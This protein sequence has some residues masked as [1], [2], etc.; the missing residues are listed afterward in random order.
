VSSAEVEAAL[1]SS[2]EHRANKLLALKE[3]QWYEKKSSRIAARALAQSL[4][5]MANADGGTLIVGLHGSDVEGVDSIGRQLNELQQASRDF[6][7]P[8]VPES[9]KLIDCIFKLQRR[10]L[11]V[12]TI[13]PSERLHQ[14]TD[15][16]TYLRVGDEKRKLSAAEAVEL[17]YDKSQGSFETTRVPAGDVTDIDEELLGTYAALL[18][19]PRPARLL[20]DRTLT[21]ADQLTVAGC[22]L[23]TAN[24]TVYLPSALVRVT[25]WSGRTR[26]TGSRQNITSDERVEGPIPRLIP[27][28]R[29]AVAKVQ[30]TRR[31]L[32]SD[33]AFENVPT[34]PEEAWYEGLLNAVVHRSYSLEGDHIHVDVFDDRIE[35]T[36]PGPFPHLIDLS[37]P[38]DARRYAR[39]PR[40]VRVC[41]DLGLTQ[42]LGEGIRR[43]FDE[44]RDAGLDDP[45]YTQTRRSVTLVL[46][47]EPTH[48]RLDARY[49]EDVGRV[50]SALRLN[51]RMSTAELTEVVGRS[52]PAV[53][54]L[55]NVMR[56]ADLIDWT[57]KSAR[58]PR[59]YWSLPGTLR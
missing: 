27:L 18:D 17:Q 51:E 45:L 23:F 34:V 39:N 55:L 28:A 35:I 6:C 38:L 57:G 50:L 8:R 24:P 49:R 41:S 46:S 47:A 52:K 14:T 48:R 33:G 30:P 4:V 22:L 1:R 32:G 13:Q 40:V 29:A 20:R 43:M 9:N 26:E 11:L 44:M 10:K 31:A 12:F 59:A 36:S 25:R 2:P 15:G 21:S 54:N 37:N 16:V 7:E 19:H 53:R 56:A 5:A 58:D 3:D 42:E